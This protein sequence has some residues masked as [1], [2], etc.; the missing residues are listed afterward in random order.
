LRG[1]VSQILAQLKNR[2]VKGEITV[3]IGPQPGKPQKAAVTS[4]AK[5]IQRLAREE[6]LDERAALKRVARERGLSKS[7][8][9]RQWQSEKSKPRK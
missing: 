2:P 1:K 9:Y 8:A 5:E 7:E 6:K 4:I 3:L